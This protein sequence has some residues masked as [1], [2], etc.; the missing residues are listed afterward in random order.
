[1]PPCNDKPDIIVGRDAEGNKY[2][3]IE[4]YLCYD[5][6]QPDGDPLMYV[7]TFNGRLY[8][9]HQNS[10][11]ASAVLPWHRRLWRWVTGLWRRGR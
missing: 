11:W 2:W 1:M 7:T 10:T 8:A 9:F 3:G 6:A 4:H 5:P